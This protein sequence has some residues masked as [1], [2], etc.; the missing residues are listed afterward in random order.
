MKV[1]VGSCHVSPHFFKIQLTKLALVLQQLD[2]TISNYVDRRFPTAPNAS[3]EQKKQ[4][5]D[6]A[7]QTSTTVYVGNLAFTTSDFQLYEVH[8]RSMYCTATDVE[9]DTYTSFLLL[10]FV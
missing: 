5:F 7:L 3:D 2:P 8:S 10:L 9:Y 1:A 4:D 6:M